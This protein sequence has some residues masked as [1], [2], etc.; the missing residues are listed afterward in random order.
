[1]APRVSVC[2]PTYNYAHF[3]S[4]AVESVLNQE[5]GDF[6]IIVQD[7]C[8]SDNTEEV[9]AGFLSDPRVKF[10]RNERN[11]GLGAN[12]NVCLRKAAGEY[13]KYVFADDLLASGDA[14][15]EM[16]GV[17][18]KDSQISLVASSRNIIDAH[19][20]VL[21]VESSFHGDLTAP[22]AGIINRCL[23]CRRNLIGEPSAVMFRRDDARR[24][25]DERYKHLLDMEMWFHLLEKGKFAYIDRPL[26]SFRIHPEQKTA[27]NIR[28]RIYLDD[29]FLLL[30]QYLDK[31][32]I[33]AG[34]VLKHYLLVDAVY[35]FWKLH[36][37][38]LLGRREASL[39]IKSIFPSFFLVYPFFKVAKPFMKIYLS[40]LR[41]MAA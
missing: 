13:V 6:E 39:R 16:A 29:Y 23:Y 8:S 22:G 41:S 7:D 17:L 9:I 33:R 11:L 38:G 34:R 20:A 31:P 3:I 37:K 14:L 30:R 40:L 15:G 32:Y 18:E 25:F 36:K 26:C 35:Q 10:G 5:F 21:R 19:S 2:I 12:W 28:S 4:S 1:M 27:E 24:G